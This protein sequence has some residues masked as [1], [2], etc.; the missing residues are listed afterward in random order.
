M[1]QRV[2]QGQQL[3]LLT[4]EQL[5]ML[6]KMAKSATLVPPP[7]AWD[8]EVEGFAEQPSADK[9]QEVWLRKQPT[10]FSVGLVYPPSSGSLSEFQLRSSTILKPPA[11]AE[12]PSVND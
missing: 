6:P 2:A 5:H 1:G 7:P 4:D 11:Q 12:T 10:V 9:I 8:A 3:H